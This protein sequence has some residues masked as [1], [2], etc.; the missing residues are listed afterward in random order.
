M[1]FVDEYKCILFFA[2]LV[3]G[4]HAELKTEVLYTLSLGKNAVAD[5]TLYHIDNVKNKNKIELPKS[6][7]S[8]FIPNF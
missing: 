1:Y 3:A 2:H 6:G 5:R 4:D 7:R 8:L